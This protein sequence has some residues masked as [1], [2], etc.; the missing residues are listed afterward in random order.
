MAVLHLV[1][2]KCVQKVHVQQNVAN[3][4]TANGIFDTIKVDGRFATNG[5]IHHGK[6]GCWNV[7]KVDTALVD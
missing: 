2:G 1:G 3:M 7:Q 5:G 6:K 4:E